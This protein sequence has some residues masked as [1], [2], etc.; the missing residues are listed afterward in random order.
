MQIEGNI[1]NRDGDGEGRN[2]IIHEDEKM[3]GMGMRMALDW[4]REVGRG[5]G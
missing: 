4:A 1:L 3:Y 2:G 5:M